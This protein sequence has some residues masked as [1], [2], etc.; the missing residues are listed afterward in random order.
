MSLDRPLVLASG[1]AH[2]RSLL[3][4]LRLDFIVDP[5]DID[6]SPLQNERPRDYVLRLAASKAQ[7]VAQRHPDALIIGSDQA[8]V[9]D[10][11]ILGKPGSLE[12]ATSQLL[13]ASGKDVRFHTGLCLHDARRGTQELVCEDYSVR[14]RHLD[15]ATV[16]RYL[17]RE[18]ALDAAGSFYSEGLGVS[19]FEAM[20]GRD[21]TSLIGLPLIALCQLLRRVG[22]AVP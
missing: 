16:E 18:P 19:L 10:D 13:A 11:V 2:R 15:R 5:A 7:T 20:E 1:S 4:R 22:V 9:R 12:R 17:A 14:F 6:E 21:P 3:D 8:C